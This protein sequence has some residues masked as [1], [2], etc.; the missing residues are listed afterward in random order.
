MRKAILLISMAAV[1]G[2]FFSS[3]TT[4]SKT[5][6]TPAHHVEFVKGDFEYSKQLTAEAVEQR[7]IGVDWARLFTKSY[8][9]V[10]TASPFNVAIPV[11]GKVIQKK[12]NLYALHKVMTENS[13][14]DIVFFPQFESKK[15]GLWPFYVETKTTV[16]TRL[17][18]IKE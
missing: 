14:Y 18:K 7:I 6:K 16:T 1:M 11:I 8:G 12:T 17:G 15:F 9:E 10:E 4:N 5:M 13:G 3:C 2:I